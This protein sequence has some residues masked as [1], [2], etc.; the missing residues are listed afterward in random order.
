MQEVCCCGGK[1][2]GGDQCAAGNALFLTRVGEDR[3]EDFAPFKWETCREQF[4][5]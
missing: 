3:E 4:G 5:K 2:E 1:V